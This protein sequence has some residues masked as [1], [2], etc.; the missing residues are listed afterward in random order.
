MI[1]A[2][3]GH[4]CIKRVYGEDG[5]APTLSTMQG[6]N[7]EPKVAIGGGAMYKDCQQERLRHGN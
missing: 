2:I 4:D 1:K 7:T 6:G 5:C 3:N